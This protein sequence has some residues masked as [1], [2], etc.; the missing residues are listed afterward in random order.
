LTDNK[1]KKTK[2]IISDKASDNLRSKP[3]GYQGLYGLEIAKDELHTFKK[4]YNRLPKA[5]E[6]GSI[7][8]AILRGEYRSFNIVSW[9]DLLKVTFGEINVEREI[10]TPDNKGLERA[11]VELRILEKELGRLPTASDKKGNVIRKAISRKKWTSFGIYTWN[12][13]M[14]KTFGRVN[15]IVPVYT[16]DEQGLQSALNTLRTFKQQRNRLPKSSDKGMS[17]IKSGI[18][19]KRWIRFGIG[20]WNDLM[21]KAFGKEERYRND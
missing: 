15:V 16:A 9:N 17:T 8:K 3:L 4:K 13:L 10:Y 21:R 18:Y 7:K 19:R 5:N 11:I 1:G 14:K 20:T 12:D 2:D 6:F